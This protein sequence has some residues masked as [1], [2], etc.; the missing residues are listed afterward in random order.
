[1]KGFREGWGGTDLDQGTHDNGTS[2]DHGVMGDSW[3][4][5][6]HPVSS[7]P[8]RKTAFLESPLYSLD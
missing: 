8:L 3:G 2:I 4:N 7:Q 1:M 5:T 6:N